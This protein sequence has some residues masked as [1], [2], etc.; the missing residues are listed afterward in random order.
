MDVVPTAGGRW[1]ARCD[2]GLSDVRALQ[3][4]AWEWLLDHEC[5]AMVPTQGVL[6][7]EVVVNAAGPPETALTEIHWVVRGK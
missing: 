7:G 6:T 5:V 4:E 3:P 2:C 1:L